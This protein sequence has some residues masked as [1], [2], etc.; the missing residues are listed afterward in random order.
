[1]WATLS[2]NRCHNTLDVEICVGTSCQ[3]GVYGST[4][5][6]PLPGDIGGVALEN[7]HEHYNTATRASLDHSS[8]ISGRTT[9]LHYLHP[10]SPL[11]LSNPV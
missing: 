9:Q 10:T 2:V 6:G 1:M 3:M 4:A 5:G 7:K 11:S 8:V